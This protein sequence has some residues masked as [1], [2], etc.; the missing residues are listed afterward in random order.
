LSDKS[1]SGNNGLNL[2]NRIDEKLVQN[3]PFFVKIKIKSTFLYKS[4]D[5]FN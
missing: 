4:D 5:I 1:G 2:T 3:N